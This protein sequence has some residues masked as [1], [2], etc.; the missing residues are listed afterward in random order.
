MDSVET[1][2]PNLCLY[3]SNVPERL[4]AI[5]LP[6]LVICF[7]DSMLVRYAFINR[8]GGKRWSAEYLRT[9]ASVFPHKNCLLNANEWNSAKADTNKPTWNNQPSQQL[10]INVFDASIRYGSTLYP[11]I[12]EQCMRIFWCVMLR[13]RQQYPSFRCTFLHSF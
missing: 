13:I 11:S 8:M 3:D 2:W 4:N 9:Q 5:R 10:L 12:Y 7:I 1:D 6:M